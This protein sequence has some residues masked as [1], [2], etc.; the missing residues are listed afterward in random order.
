MAQSVAPLISVHVV[1]LVVHGM[2]FG[3][4]KELSHSAGCPDS[5]GGI[6]QVWGASPRPL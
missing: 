5:P 1:A 3:L 2:D 6:G 4:P